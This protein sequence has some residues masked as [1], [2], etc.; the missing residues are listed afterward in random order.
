M[1]NRFC[2]SFCYNFIISFHSL[3]FLNT[4]LAFREYFSFRRI[5]VVLKR[6]ECMC[7][8]YALGSFSTNPLSQLYI[9]WHDCNSFSVNSTKVHV[10]KKSHKISL[11]CFLKCSHR[12]TCY[13][14]ICSEIMHNFSYESSERQFS[15]KE[16]CILLISPNL[17]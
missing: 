6:T 7:F 8:S 5:W 13:S 4:G 16:F 12:H 15:N 14:E 2:I 9:F 1:M 11:C 3:F 17:S 10:F